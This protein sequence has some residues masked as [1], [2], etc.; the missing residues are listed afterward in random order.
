LPNTD[1]AII[2]N[3]VTH[4]G[5]M[6]FNEPSQAA[7]GKGAE[8]IYR[9]SRGDRRAD[10]VLDNREQQEVSAISVKDHATQLLE[11]VRAQTKPRSMKPLK[12]HL[13]NFIEDVD[14][15]L[16]DNRFLQEFSDWLDRYS[17]R[18]FV[19]SMEL[20]DT[21]L[22][23]VNRLRTKVQGILS[24]SMTI[25]FEHTEIPT[26]T[27]QKASDLTRAL[28]RA[29][30]IK[31][32]AGAGVGGR[33]I[34]IKIA[35]DPNAL[36]FRL[37][38][39]NMRAVPV[40]ADNVRFNLDPTGAI[41]INITPVPNVKEA[42]RSWIDPGHELHAFNVNGKKLTDLLPTIDRRNVRSI[43][44]LKAREKALLKACMSLFL[45]EGFVANPR[46]SNYLAAHTNY[47]YFLDAINPWTS[48]LVARNPNQAATGLSPSVDITQGEDGS[49]N[50]EVV[51]PVKG[52][53]AYGFI[54]IEPFIEIDGEIRAHFERRVTLDL[55]TNKIDDEFTLLSVS[56]SSPLF[57]QFMM[58]PK[59]LSEIWHNELY[60]LSAA[61][62]FIARY[63]ADAD[64]LAEWVA[65][66]R[67]IIDDPLYQAALIGWEGEADAFFEK[68]ELQIN[69]QYS[70]LLSAANEINYADLSEE[71]RLALRSYFRLRSMRAI[72]NSS[73]LSEDERLAVSQSK[74]ELLRE[75][76]R[77][78]KVHR[79]AEIRDRAYSVIVDHMQKDYPVLNNFIEAIT[80]RTEGATRENKYKLC[81]KLLTLLQ[82]EWLTEA[83]R[84]FLTSNP[85]ITILNIDKFTACTDS[86]AFAVVQQDLVDAKLTFAIAVTSIFSVANNIINTPSEGGQVILAHQ[87]IVR[88]QHF[89]SL[90]PVL[91][92]RLIGVDQPS[93]DDAAVLYP[94]VQR[95]MLECLNQIF[96]N[97]SDLKATIEHFVEGFHALGNQIQNTMLFSGFTDEDRAI[98]QT[99]LG[100][101]EAQ[102]HRLDLTTLT[103]EVDVALEP[104]KRFAKA[105]RG[106]DISN[107]D[108]A[109]LADKLKDVPRDSA[110]RILNEIIPVA[111]EDSV[112][113]IINQL[114]RDGASAEEKQ[115]CDVVHSWFDHYTK[116]RLVKLLKTEVTAFQEAD[117]IKLLGL[118]TKL[119]AEVAGPTF[120][121]ETQTVT[122]ILENNPQLGF[123]SQAVLREIDCTGKTDREILS[124][125]AEK[126][127]QIAALFKMMQKMQDEG[128]NYTS[129]RNAIINMFTDKFFVGNRH[130]SDAF[131]H[132]TNYLAAEYNDQE[133]T[134]ALLLA[135]LNILVQKGPKI[136]RELMPVPRAKSGRIN[137]TQAYERVHHCFSLLQSSMSSDAEEHE[138][139]AHLQKQLTKFWAAKNRRGLRDLLGSRSRVI[140][141]PLANLTDVDYLAHV[142]TSDPESLSTARYLQAFVATNDHLRTDMSTRL[143]RA[144]ISS[145]EV[146]AVA[147][148]LERLLEPY[149]EPVIGAGHQSTE[150]ALQAA[151][152]TPTAAE[153][154]EAVRPFEIDVDESAFN[155]QEKQ[156]L[157]WFFGDGPKPR[158]L[159]NILPSFN[160]MF[161][162]SRR[163]QPRLAA[164]LDSHMRF[165]A[166]SV[167]YMVKVCEHLRNLKN[168]AENAN[169][170]VAEF[171]E[172]YLR[173]SVVTRYPELRLENF[174]AHLL[175]ELARG[176]TTEDSSARVHEIIEKYRTK[177]DVAAI[178]LLPETV[179]ISL[180]SQPRGERNLFFCESG[181]HMLKLDRVA[182]GERLFDD[183]CRRNNIMMLAERPNERSLQSYT[184]PL[185]GPCEFIFSTAFGAIGHPAAITYNA[186]KTL[187]TDNDPARFL[188]ITDG[189]RI[190][191][192]DLNVDVILPGTLTAS[193]VLRQFNETEH[194]YE[195]QSLR[196]SNPVLYMMIHY[197]GQV[198]SAFASLQN[199]GNGLGFTEVLPQLARLAEHYEAHPGLMHE[200]VS[201]H[202]DM[203]VKTLA[204]A[205]DLAESLAGLDFSESLG[206]N[207]KSKLSEMLHPALGNRD[208]QALRSV[209]ELRAAFAREAGVRGIELGD[210]VEVVV[211]TSAEH[212]Q[213]QKAPYDPVRSGTD[214]Q[215]AHRIID[216]LLDERDAAINLNMANIVMFVNYYHNSRKEL[217]TDAFKDRFIARLFEKPTQTED[218]IARLE[219]VIAFLKTY[220]STAGSM[221]EVPQFQSFLEGVLEGLQKTSTDESVVSDAG[222]DSSILD[223]GAV[224]AQ[225]AVYQ[226]F[227]KINAVLKL[228]DNE[229]HMLSRLQ[230]YLSTNPNQV[231]LCDAMQACGAKSVAVS[232]KLILALASIR[233]SSLRLSKIESLITQFN[234]DND[235]LRIG[236]KEIR[237]TRRALMAAT[238]TSRSTSISAA[239]QQGNGANV[240]IIRPQEHDVKKSWR[241]KSPVRPLRAKDQRYLMKTDIPVYVRDA[242]GQEIELSS[243]WHNLFNEAALKSNLVLAL[244]SK[245]KYLATEGLTNNNKHKAQNILSAL[246]V[247]VATQG[248]QQLSLDMLKEHLKPG[249]PLYDAIQEHNGIKGVLQTALCCARIN[250]DTYNA[251]LAVD[252]SIDQ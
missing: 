98:L 229:Q 164:T 175:T 209:D 99:R 131:R 134:L 8:Y 155:S 15:R 212:V 74:E 79:Q 142:V 160:R 146:V 9:M 36:D 122:E 77:E 32:V 218:L 66:T 130:K 76:L 25:E 103:A 59:A 120:G 58:M 129:L 87:D 137:F 211:P 235:L 62:Q 230:R 170:T 191:R 13:A 124:N 232:R 179:E 12:K 167:R 54:G 184:Q 28:T 247:I 70:H 21:F 219:Q 86:T 172:E 203:K 60:S 177:E 110:V 185:I 204:G 145:A 91:E 90:Y 156:L 150:H 118:A 5:D 149:E 147:R 114:S 249:H 35:D 75:C 144:K 220:A 151:A 178:E 14:A 227:A 109:D 81:K 53:L 215:Y 180:D 154:P 153:R 163:N 2:A 200:W 252:P 240:R 162:A 125:I 206:A 119:T 217:T 141:K 241:A 187:L 31:S 41:A 102:L 50:Y 89:V 202:A 121:N 192:P 57:K 138:I 94:A 181:T 242:N 126:A 236:D 27:I 22:Q 116:T 42:V 33:E 143:K 67:Q 65:D 251:L 201:C 93:R 174:R 161:V 38:L 205:L 157:K 159:Q 45:T 244:L 19:S 106:D 222:S 51:I 165:S 133:A 80:V 83:Q 34:A 166:Q 56:C 47:A 193:F 96:K 173:S 186:S 195:V 182:Y 43:E 245:V 198:R 100:P 237:D 231:K 10:R 101:I 29:G 169:A 71:E 3:R 112:Q 52:V 128:A 61:D 17:Q 7:T 216:L 97:E 55:A 223:T 24:R 243:H 68:P 171:L 95:Q 248:G 140:A 49:I 136:E 214:M 73:D 148:A 208:Q 210:K 132:W 84:E 123:I 239:S 30:V 176:T 82:R 85:E 246:Q 37:L 228:S 1:I 199:T 72:V 152:S 113:R 183:D 139:D 117:A 224:G 250:T 40:L 189:Y 63:V 20:A 115:L 39:D 108:L 88:L 213:P 196:A 78:Y 225:G 158:D 4:G 207:R 226:V 48:G 6:A 234:D 69:S 105:L 168:V 111:F 16:H 190:V 11:F 46:C 221:T 188:N 64:V 44:E 26:A 18:S 104:W 238:V 135:G 194:R 92:E 107:D 23:L 127:T 197:Q 233:Q